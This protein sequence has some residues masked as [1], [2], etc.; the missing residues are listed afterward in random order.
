V[1]FAVIPLPIEKPG[2]GALLIERNATVEYSE[3]ELDLAAEFASLAFTAGDEAAM[4]LEARQA[5]EYDGESGVYKPEVMEKALKTAH[6][7]ALLQRQP[8]N[9]MRVGLDGAG[10]SLRALAAIVRDEIDYG[11]TVGRWTAD[12]LLVLAPGLHPAGARELAER[13]L[14]SARKQGIALSI[15]VAPMKQGERGSTGM[16]ERA[17][18]ALA[19]VRAAGGN[20]VQLVTASG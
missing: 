4:E 12:E 7:E 10:Q 3:L 20:Q 6:Q 15:A 13:I 9:V 14:A 17:A 16:L 19:R 8:F 2:W 18:Q 5:T 11:E 1:Q